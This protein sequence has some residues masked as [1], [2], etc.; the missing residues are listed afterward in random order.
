MLKSLCFLRTKDRIKR[1]LTNKNLR[2]KTIVSI[3]LFV[4]LFLFG[5]TCHAQFLKKLGKGIEKTAKAID[6]V[7]GTDD[8]ESTSNVEVNGSKITCSTPHKNI[9]VKLLSAEMAGNNFIVEFIITNTGQDIKDYRISGCSSGGCSHTQAFDNVGNQCGVNVI[10]GASES[11][12][13]GTAGSSLLTDSPIKVRVIL[14][15]FSSKATSISQLRLK[16]VNHDYQATYAEEGYFI[17]KNI[18]IERSQE[19]EISIPT[20]TSTTSN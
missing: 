4:V 19:E 15:R 11:W 7:L 9:R 5:G 10:F 8:S 2:M 17:F 6:N 3:L 1:L 14:G 16:G 12:H 13:G 18:P 20:K